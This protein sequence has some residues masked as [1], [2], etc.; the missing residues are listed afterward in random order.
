MGMIDALGMGPMQQMVASQ[1]QWHGPNVAPTDVI[2]PTMAAYQ[3]AMQKYMLDRQ[4]QNA[5]QGALFGLAGAGLGAW[6]LGGF[7]M[8]SWLGGAA[9]AAA[10]PQLGQ[11]TLGGGAFE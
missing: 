4:K 2:G 9:G 3:A 6:G 11:Y 10:S 1:P 7:N 5:T 8:P